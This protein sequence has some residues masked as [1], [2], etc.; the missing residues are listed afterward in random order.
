[1][2]G[3]AALA[4][5]EY[6]LGRDGAWRLLFL[7]GIWT[8]ELWRET[9]RRLENDGQGF[10]RHPETRK[11]H[12]R[13]GGVG[14]ELYLKIY[15]PS[16]FL[17]CLKD[18][19]R[20]SRAHRA[21]RVS[22]VL[23]RHGFHVPTGVAAGEIRAFRRVKRAF[24]LT[25]S[26]PGIPLPLYLQS[27]YAPT[28]EGL[29]MKR[30]RE[31]LRQLALEI[32]RMHSLGFVH[33]DLIPSNI[34]VQIDEEGARFFTLDHDR[35]RRYPAW[36]PNRLWRRN[37]VQLNRMELAGISVRDRIR[38]LK[39]YLGCRNLAP[40]ERR[41]ARQLSSETRRRRL[42]NEKKNLNNQ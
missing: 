36:L 39:C 11:I 13:N 16:T 2:G 9:S 23:K 29:G 27:Q 1:V 22:H 31:Y 10:R 6:R 8:Q 4:D 18:L 21:F 34:L 19:L 25:L 24:L 12:H 40:G 7:P 17:E 37:L 33:G 38:F 14:I 42:R 5:A 35:T 26:V 15:H 28:G 20:Q 32:R 3:K 41:L 30:K